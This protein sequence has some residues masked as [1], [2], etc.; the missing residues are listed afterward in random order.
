MSHLVD[1]PESWRSAR[2]SAGGSIAPGE[3]AAA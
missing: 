1:V 2:V 3:M